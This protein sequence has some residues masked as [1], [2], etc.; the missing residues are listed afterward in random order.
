MHFK[1]MFYITYIIT[2]VKHNKS[3]AYQDNLKLL[4]TNPK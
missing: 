1:H 4:Q 3:Y 2:H